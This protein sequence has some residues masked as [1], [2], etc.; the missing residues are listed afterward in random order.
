MLYLFIY[1]KSNFVHWRLFYCCF[2]MLKMIVL[3]SWAWIRRILWTCNMKG[4][5]ISELS[6]IWPI[7]KFIKQQY[8]TGLPLPIKDIRCRHDEC[9]EAL[10]KKSGIKSRS[11]RKWSKICPGKQKS[12]SLLGLFNQF[13]II[14]SYYNTRSVPH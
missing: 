3:L 8:K 2:F 10:A 1:N 9:F 14:Y 7:T 13:N 11:L 5:E 6:H 12:N 4:I